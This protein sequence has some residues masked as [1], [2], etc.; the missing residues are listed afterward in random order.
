MSVVKKG[1]WNYS[2]LLTSWPLL[3]MVAIAFCFRM[4]RLPLYDVI[5]ADGIGYV[6]AARNLAAGDMSSLASNGFY[7]FMTWLFGQFTLDYEISG[8]LVS[9]VFGSLLVVPLYLLG[10]EM[11]SRNTAISACLVTSVWPSLLGW[12][13]EVMTQA[14]Y[15]TLIVTGYYF[16]WRMYRDESSRFA[17]LAGV[18]LGFAFLTR[19]EAAL[20]FVVLPLFPFWN[21]YREAKKEIVRPIIM[22]AGALVLL[23]GMHIVMLRLTTGS[24]LLSAKTSAALND[25]LGRYLKI[26]D[27]RFIPNVK[28]TGYMD[29]LVNHPGFLW[30]NASMNLLELWKTMV[31]PPLWILALT[32]FV[33]NGFKSAENVKRFFL[34]SSFAPLAVIV[35]FYY[36]GPEYTQPYLPVFFLWC[37]EGV[38]LAERKM[39]RYLPDTWTLLYEKG[40]DMV[41]LTMLAA[42]IYSFSLFYMQIPSKPDL[43]KYSYQDDGARRDYKRIGL[44]L[45]EHLPPGKIMT[46]SSR[47]GYYAEREWTMIPNTDVDGVI[48]AAK[49]EG[50]RYLVI[51]GSSVGSNPRLAPL[52][53]PLFNDYYQNH[54]FF[55]ADRQKK[56]Y[57]TFALIYR[58]PSSLGIV[59]HEIKEK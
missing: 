34:L 46:R 22:Y 16:V 19:T 35:L 5:S 28:Q 3:L 52:C 44:L 20:L 56:N 33:A 58:D 2:T 59:V 50:V 37:A 36:I 13:C 27:L 17:A 18:T 45:K 31:P 4:L 40:T 57:G 14:T 24:W 29:I 9:V 47:I 26:D 48:K 42:L 10:C 49:Q 25:A 1:R 15:T 43:S 53:N 54:Y 39:S 51:D 11:F 23:C 6:Y 38:Q 7:V 32:G 8:R 55:V 41:P 12:S 21:K 30:T